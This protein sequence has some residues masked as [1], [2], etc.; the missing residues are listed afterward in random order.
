MIKILFVSTGLQTGG[1]ERMLVKILHSIDRTRFEPHVVSL[2]DEGTLGAEIRDMGVPLHCLRMNTLPGMLFAP[3]RLVALIRSEKYAILQ[4]WMYHGNVMA[5][6]G[7]LLSFQR[8]VLLFGIRHTAYDLAKEKVF[9]ALAIRVNAFLTRFAQSCLFNSEISLQVHKKIGFKS[10]A[11]SVIPN[12]FDLRAYYPN[13]L[14]VPELRAQWDLQDKLVVGLI[15]RFDPAKDHHN[16]LRAAG[17][18]HAVMPDVRFLLA[19][20]GV[21]YD[22]PELA[23]WVDTYRLRDAVLLLGERNDIPVL[24]N[25]VDIACLSSNMEAFPNVIGEA[26]ACGKPCVVTD[27]GDCRSIVGQTGLVVDAEDSDALAAALLKLLALPT[28]VRAELGAAARQKIEDEFRIDSVV[29][30][31]MCYYED[32]FTRGVA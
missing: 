7:R 10:E 22:N 3:L 8:S 32:L 2:I 16:F 28:A 15:A 17:K 31:Y 1:A 14:G 29:E 24:Q 21:T 13:P 12:G 19:G 23:G 18:V 9:T 4:G 20:F 26:M 25:L 5:W 11:M 6:V 30:K 27:V